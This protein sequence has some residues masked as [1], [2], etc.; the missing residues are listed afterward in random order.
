[1]GADGISLIDRS[2]FN[3]FINKSWRFS[4]RFVCL[5]KPSTRDKPLRAA[6][7]TPRRCILH[8]LRLLNTAATNYLLCFFYKYNHLPKLWVMVAV[9]LSRYWYTTTTQTSC[10]CELRVSA[11]MTRDVSRC[12]AGC[13]LVCRRSVCKYLDAV[14]TFLF[15]FADTLARV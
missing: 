9:L 1:M 14:Y 10:D 8:R 11:E 7:D 2:Q 15:A 4:F 5:L 13:R 6:R 12:V 3:W